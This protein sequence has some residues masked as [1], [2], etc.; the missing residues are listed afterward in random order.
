MRAFAALAIPVVVCALA[1]TA[2]ADRAD[3]LFR[4]GKKLLADKKYAEAC[5]AFEESDRID[6][7]I[8][9]KLNVARCYQEWGK[10]ATAWRWY[11]DAE[12]MAIGARDARAKKIRELI[13]ELDPSVPRLTIRLPAGVAAAGVAIRLDGIALEAAAIGVERRVDPGPHQ[14]DAVIDGETQTKVVPI[15]RGGSSEITLEAPR[16]RKPERDQPIPVA[17]PVAAPDPYRTRRLIGLGTAGAGAL[18][19]GIATIVAIRARGDY[20]RAIT[21]RCNGAKDMC[22]SEGLKRT[23]SARSRANIATV[24]AVGGLAAIA[25]GV[26]LYVASRRADAATDQALYLAPSVDHSATGV[27]VGGAF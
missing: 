1:T 12:N 25:G 6:P 19:F 3:Q 15:E 24:F 13:D 10:L 5:T 14:I 2:R 18:S 11:G 20:N 21:G 7:G 17:A 16:Q 27:V 4:I 23:D 9:A 8:G 26:V 22:D